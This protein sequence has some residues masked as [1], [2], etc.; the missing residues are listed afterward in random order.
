M[1]TVTYRLR[2]LEAFRYVYTDQTANGNTHVALKGV[3][4]EISPE[5]PGNLTSY[6]ANVELIVLD[7]ATATKLEALWSAYTS[8]SAVTA[9][10]PTF[11]M[12]FVFADA[13]ASPTPEAA[14]PST[15]SDVATAEA[16]RAAEP[17][18][19]APEV[20]PA[21]PVETAVAPEPVVAPAETVAPD[22]TLPVEP[23]PITPPPPPTLPA[24]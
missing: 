12:G 11:G 1:D 19:A 18:A 3:R 15:A 6:T 23:D 5:L 10:E 24:L 21:A 8:N 17:V 14:P 7:P 2:K 22:V 16:P 4:I 9:Q 20:A 13:A